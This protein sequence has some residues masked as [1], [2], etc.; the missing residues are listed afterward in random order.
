MDLKEK[1]NK[2]VY[3]AIDVL[4]EQLDGG[5]KLEKKPDTVLLGK[6]G[7]LDSIGFVNLI[8]LL[9]E[10]CQSECGV[11]ISLTDALGTMTDDNPFQTVRS[12]IEY[13][14]QLVRDAV[15]QSS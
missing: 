9:E 7:K 8:V 5:Q 14:Q 11:T 10:H 15:L 1:V 6:N 12:L 2:A 3:E 4:N 13:L